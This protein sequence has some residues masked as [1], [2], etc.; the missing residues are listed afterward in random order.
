MKHIHYIYIGVLAFL[1]ACSSEESITTDSNE[2]AKE[3]I[4]LSAGIVDGSSKATTRTEPEP[5]F[6]ALTKADGNN[7]NTQLALQVNGNW[8]H[9]E[10]TTLITK[11]TTA[12]VGTATSNQNAMTEY[13]PVL[14]WDDYGTADPD[15][16]N[17]RTQGLTIY[18]VAI[19]SMSVTDAGL[20]GLLAA[21]ADWTALNW[22]LPH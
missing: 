8:K 1:I 16:A 18:G 20:S 4:K 6:L 17:G 12:T 3:P 11:T 10:T 2:K 13:N 19:D 9:G 14:Y 21:N 15:N 22:T 5:S 7:A